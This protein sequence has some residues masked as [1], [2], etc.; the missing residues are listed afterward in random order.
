MSLIQTHIK[1]NG[2]FYAGE[3]HDTYKSTP[4]ATGWQNYTDSEIPHLLFV[5]K[6][7]QAHIIEGQRNLKSVL[8]RI[9]QRVRDGQIQF[10]R[11]EILKVEA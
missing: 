2:L 4:S 1:V 5:E 9:M 3:A 11:I 10:E 6:A 7:E 8:D